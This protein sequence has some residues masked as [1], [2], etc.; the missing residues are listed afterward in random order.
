M[1]RKR[2]KVTVKTVIPVTSSDKRRA[3]WMNEV[4]INLNIQNEYKRPYIRMFGKVKYIKREEVKMYIE[5]KI[6]VHYE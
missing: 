5:H 4:N 6:T 1:S 3:F 2:I